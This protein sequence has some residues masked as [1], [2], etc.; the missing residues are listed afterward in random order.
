MVSVGA[1][2]GFCVAAGGFC[3]VVLA[4]VVVTV[5]ESTTFVV[6]V[7]ASFL[8]TQAVV[9]NRSAIERHNFGDIVLFSGL[10]GITAES[11]CRSCKDGTRQDLFAHRQ[12][13]QNDELKTT[14]RGPSA[15]RLAAAGSTGGLRALT[16]ALIFAD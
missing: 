11:V 14:C 7:V 5:V 1:G 4:E 13:V 6:S 8:A 15:E 16:T 2:A 10:I 9:A 3:V 12:R